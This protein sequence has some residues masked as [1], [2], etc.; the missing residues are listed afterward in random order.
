MSHNPLRLQLLLKKYLESSISKEELNE[1]WLLLS[2]LSEND[3]VEAE[4][5]EMWKYESDATKGND[6]DNVYATIKN[7]IAENEID[8]GKV[9][10][11]PVLRLWRPLA[12]AAVLLSAIATTYLLLPTRGSDNKTIAKVDILPIKNKIAH[13]VINLPDGS[14]VTLNHDSKLDYPAAFDGNTREVYLTGEAF[15]D[16][17][18]DNKKPFIVHTGKYYTQVLGTAFN[19]KAYSED[20][21]ILVT[22]TRGKVKVE[23]QDGKK[24][25]SYI[26]PG[27]QVKIVD[28]IATHIA[29]VKVDVK[30]ILE[31]KKEE[32][33]FDNT[34]FDEA[35][36]IL[37]NSFGVKLKLKNPSL[38]NCKFSGKFKNDN[39]EKI[40]KII[41]EL[42]KTTYRIE[43]NI[44]WISG[45][46]C[47]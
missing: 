46:G 47:K 43:N 14:V 30:K 28:S 33:V 5:E 37:N 25:V 6:W 2:D 8:F 7:R 16:I 41:T 42:T 23:K 4:L 31:W 32:L 3:L 20:K 24:L 13:Q 40:L 10:R 27:E 29:P 38:K 26:L 39:L 19:I 11:A 45:S 17:K 34:T 1:F 44:V 21:Q 35:N 12:V 36:I 15:F 22:V 18:H 9:S